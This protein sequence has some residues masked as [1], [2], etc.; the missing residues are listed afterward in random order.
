ML[1]STLLLALS[2]A[3]CVSP[4]DVHSA[5]ESPVKACQLAFLCARD[6]VDCVGDSCDEDSACVSR[7]MS[8]HDDA[9]S[10][11]GERPESVGVDAAWG[12]DG[13]FFD[14]LFETQFVPGLCPSENISI[15]GCKWDAY[16]CAEGSCEVEGL[17][18]TGHDTDPTTDVTG[19]DTGSGTETDGDTDTDTGTS[20]DTQGTDTDDMTGGSTDA[21]T[22]DTGGSG[23]SGSTGGLHGD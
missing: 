12:C 18:S 10:P 14:G 1:G 8:E 5:P 6:C 11:C 13:S 19:T 9:D 17:T 3:A 4:V 23:S 16:R 22:T 20:G 15:C 21:T 7:C 2:L